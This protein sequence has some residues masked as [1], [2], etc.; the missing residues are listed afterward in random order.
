MVSF[1]R[2]VHIILIIVVV[3]GIFLIYT[4]NESR[5]ESVQTLSLTDM[6]REFTEISPVNESE[7]PRVWLLG[8]P[9]DVRC[10]GVY[11]NVRQLC[12]DLH[13]TIAG[14]DNFNINEVEEGDLV[15]FCDA[16]IGRYVGLKEVE[17]FI[18]GGGRVILAAGLAK[19][20]E[21]SSLWRALGIKQMFEGEDCEE[22]LFEEPLLPFQPQW[23]CRYDGPSD[24]AWL[25]VSDDASVYVRNA[26]NSVPIL[27]THAWQKGSVCLINGIFLADARCM[28]LLTGAIASLLPDF[29]YPVL[30][31][32]VVFLD[33]FPVLTPE[34]DEL[35]RQ[36]YGYSA[37]G[38]L[39]DVMWPAFQGISLRTNTYYTSSILGLASSEESFGP[40]NDAVFTTI[41]KSS[42]QFGGE[43]VYAV[44]CPEDGNIVFNEEL[45]EQFSTIFSNYTVEGLAMKTDNYSPEMLDVPGA[46]IRSV[47]GMLGSS[48]MRL[49]WED[50]FTVFPA[51]TTGNSME[52]GNFFAVYSVL[53]AY[54]MVSHV[55]D[56]SKLITV[57]GTT[58]S[59]DSDKLQINFFESEVLA[60]TPWLESRTLAQTEGDVRSY[61]NM[62]YGWTKNGNCIEL[63]C[64]GAAK[65]QAF[66]YHTGGRIAD[67]EGLTYEDV[68]NGYYLL[69][70]QEN[71]GVIMLEEGK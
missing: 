52:D 27:Y 13:L 70:I 41:C 40:V 58:A 15:I 30:G 28:G 59:W 17:D 26:G 55:F 32:K 35:C 5:P 57:D 2:F 14:E 44:D 11:G 16:S 69:R 66:F 10:G 56:V 36:M 9:E 49:S 54:G 33:N 37:E 48:T 67:A 18:A 47:R 6:E 39:R 4:I 34:D 21:D 1:K 68:G 29:V 64:S 38:F 8:D 3:G 31:V 23:A 51:A 63:N 65:G 62:D 53:G 19:E 20:E 71:R 25:D 7:K 42:L 60:P 46:D 12:E 45:M 22:L 24:S 43:L 50:G 61:Q